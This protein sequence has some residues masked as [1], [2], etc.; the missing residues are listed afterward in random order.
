VKTPAALRAFR[1]RNFRW[2]FIGQSGS[3]IGSWMQ[4][5]AVG[6]LV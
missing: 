2:F 3:M 6:W 1:H 4:Q 5:I